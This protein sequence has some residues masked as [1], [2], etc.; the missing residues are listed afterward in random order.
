MQWIRVLLPLTVV[1]LFT[2]CQ[3]YQAK[4]LIPSEILKEVEA[5]RNLL[6]AEHKGEKVTALEGKEE[7]PAYEN[8]PPSRTGFV[9]M[10]LWMRQYSPK[11][12]RALAEYDQAQSLADIDTPFPNPEIAFG[13]LIGSNLGSGASHRI[14]PM[15]EFGFRIPL[16]GRLSKQD[17][18]N[19]ALADEAL[20]SLIV[21][22]R[23]EYLELR[24]LFSNWV[25]AEKR[26]TIQE[27]IRESAQKTM[28]LTKRLVDAGAAS[29][30]DLGLMELETVQHEAM[31]KQVES[32]RMKVEEGLSRLIGINIEKIRSV[33]S[34]D[35]PEMNRA[36]SSLDEAKDIMVANN[37]SLAL[38][39]A[40]YEVSEK[41]LQLEIKKQYPDLRLGAS[42]EGDPGD[43][44]KIW[45]LGIGISLPIFDR[46][47]QGIEL[48]VKEREKVR[49]A[50]V[51]TL[52][53][54]LATLEGLYERYDLAK[55][56]HRLLHDIALPK[57]EANLEVALQSIQVG[58]ID[59]LK[60]L[61][62]VRTM[63]F[64]MIEVIDAE[65]VTRESLSE[66]EQVMGVPLVLFPAESM[67]DYLFIPEKAEN[68]VND[69]SKKS[70]G[71]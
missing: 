52:N 44:K 35:L 69:E 51:A 39:R 16:S 15:V 19:R 64:L 18:I 7:R 55:E 40:G 49:S 27:S 56:K 23:Q 41:Q 67:D 68:S 53:E 48:A 28:D 46:N 60:Y 32:E 58:S 37:P 66:L 43:T 6:A 63:R 9:K 70:S 14:Q 26:L 65:R 10:A 24:R 3:T 59:S 25:L 5:T 21:I 34:P 57:A 4:P 11:L 31:L 45:G 38:L 30:L 12:L 61:E 33:Y 47:Q 22:H 20:L 42:Y 54:S 8:D 29:A 50:Y 1:L 62:V 36:A 2:G 17:D 71:N 13:P